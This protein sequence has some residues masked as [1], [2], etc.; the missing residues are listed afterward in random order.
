MTSASDAIGYLYRKGNQNILSFKTTDD[1]ACGARPQHLS[2]QEIVLTE[3]DENGKLIAHWDR[4]YPELKEEQ[5]V[6]KPS[7]KK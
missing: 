7:K 2:N 3:R 4:I 6:E 5:V 1:V